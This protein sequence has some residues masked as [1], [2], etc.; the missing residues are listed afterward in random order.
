MS[1][2]I[3]V[4]ASNRVATRAGE[5]GVSMGIA[6]HYTTERVMKQG[7]ILGWRVRLWFNGGNKYVTEV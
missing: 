1:K 4:F 2:E 6:S 5:I 7:A 3:A